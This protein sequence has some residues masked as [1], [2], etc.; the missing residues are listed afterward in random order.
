[1]LNDKIKRA[2]AKH[3]SGQY[4]FRHKLI[5]PIQIGFLCS[6]RINT[7]YKSSTLHSRPTLPRKLMHELRVCRAGLTDPR[8]GSTDAF[9]YIQPVI[10]EK[11]SRRSAGHA[12]FITMKLNYLWRHARWSGHCAKRN[13]VAEF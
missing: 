12:Y 10:A 3:T 11:F 4:I 8:V 5:K 7:N 1:M 2:R 9:C 6:K 13:A